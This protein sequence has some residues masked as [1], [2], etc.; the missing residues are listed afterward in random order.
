ML[1]GLWAKYEDDPAT[2]PWS[3]FHLPHAPP[4]AAL[5]TDAAS[6]TALREERPP[7]T[8]H[9]RELVIVLGGQAISALGGALAMTVVPL[10]VI[11]LTGSGLMMGVVGVLQTLP[12]LVL[13]L[14]AGAL[15]DRWDRR[16]MIIWSDLGRAVLTA[17]VPIAAM[18]D[19]DV[20]AVV[21]LVTFPINALRVVFLAAWTAVMPSLVRS[22][23]VGKASGYAEALFNLS[24]IVGPALAGFLVSTVGAAPE[25]VIDAASSV[26]AISLML[27]RRPLRAERSE[28][29][30]R[31]VQDIREGVRYLLL[32]PVLRAA[33]PFWSTVSVITAPLAAAAIYMLTVDRGQASDVVGVTLSSYG[34][35]ALVGALAATRLMHGR[36]GRLMLWANAVSGIALIAS[37]LIREPIAQPPLVAVVGASGSLAL[38][39]YLTL[40]TTIPPGRLLGRVGST[41]RTI[42]VG[43]QPVG[44]W[45]E[46][47]SW[48]CAGRGQFIVT[49]VLLLLTSLGFA[50][51]RP[52]RE[53]V[54]GAGPP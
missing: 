21:L 51:S 46:A 53:A 18:F 10:L 29:P 32:E 42:S 16:G 49:A 33:V 27:V 2:G 38:V 7:A 5:T 13:G 20:M 47:S 34:V 44:C 50:V 12:D 9:N 39:A 30:T 52:L 41:A 43:L 6:G 3:R 24:F 23:D 40:R 31:L 14:P 25:L 37:A 45:W 22:D 15:A 4:R 36:L 8:W 11:A 26:S 1:R 54:A 35:G 28:G 17:L 48:T 19:W